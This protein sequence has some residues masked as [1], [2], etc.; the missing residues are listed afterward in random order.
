MRFWPTLL[1]MKSVPETLFFRET[2][3]VADITRKGAV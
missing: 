2:M 3:T 1:I